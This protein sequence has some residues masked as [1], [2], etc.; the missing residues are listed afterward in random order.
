MR[1]LLAEWL[2]RFLDDPLAWSTSA[3]LADYRASWESEVL[4]P[5]GHHDAI[6]ERAS[7]NPDLLRRHTKYLL[8]HYRSLRSAFLLPNADE[9]ELVLEQL[10]LLFSSF[11]RV[12]R[13]HMAELA[14]NRVDDE[15]FLE[16]AEQ[17]FDPAAERG[18]ANYDF[19]E[20]AP[21]RTLALW[22]E[23]YWQRE[24]ILEAWKGVST[25]RRRKLLEGKRRQTTAGLEPRLSENSAEPSPQLDWRAQKSNLSNFLLPPAAV[26]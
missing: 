20:L 1:T 19:D 4:F 23:T 26:C 21:Y 10:I 2:E 14:W 9:V 12:Y 13:M 18:P 3:Q 17:T 15:R 5:S 6:I 8:Q 25:S 24:N 7:S 22:I 16:L 11:Q